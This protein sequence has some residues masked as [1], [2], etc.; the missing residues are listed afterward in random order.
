MALDGI[1]VERLL[2]GAV[3][4]G[5]DPEELLRKAGID[6]SVHGNERQQQPNRP[7]A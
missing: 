4:K 5:C 7:T 3:L 1:A 6:P 2:Q